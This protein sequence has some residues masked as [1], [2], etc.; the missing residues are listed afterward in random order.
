M[1]YGKV[2]K[3]IYGKVENLE[4][5]EKWLYTLDQSQKYISLQG[6]RSIVF[7]CQSLFY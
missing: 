3:M 4:F 6:T 5:S 2:V 1:I 7:L